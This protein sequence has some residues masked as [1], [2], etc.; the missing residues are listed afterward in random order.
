VGLWTRFTLG[1][2]FSRTAHSFLSMCSRGEWASNLLSLTSWSCLVCFIHEKG[3]VASACAC[4]C[5][6]LMCP[7]L[8]PV[9]LR[10]LV[11]G[12]NP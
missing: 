5:S 3:A 12:R 2:S 4:A 11:F 8:K 7:D 1:P 10:G 6:Y 9:R